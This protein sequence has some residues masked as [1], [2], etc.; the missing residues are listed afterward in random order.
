MTVCEFGEAPAPISASASCF[1]L[2]VRFSICELDAL[3]VRSRIADIGP[4]AAFSVPRTSEAWRSKSLKARVASSRS[5]PSSL[6]SVGDQA[7]SCAGT[8]DVYVPVCRLTS[9]RENKRA[10]EGRQLW[11]AAPT[12]GTAITGSL[13]LLSSVA[14]PPL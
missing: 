3:S 2:T 12:A 11:R 10:S 7:A 1:A 13:V 14:M 4:R 6:V 8:A 5:A 9:E